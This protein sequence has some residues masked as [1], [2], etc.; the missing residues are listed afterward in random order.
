MFLGIFG[1]FSGDFGA[2]N[3]VFRTLYRV[4]G[5]GLGFWGDMGGTATHTRGDTS[6]HPRTRHADPNTMPTRQR[7]RRVPTT[8]S[9]APKVRPTHSGNYGDISHAIL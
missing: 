9:R 6:D 7:G 8:A 5:S 4:G 3:V 1:V 2:K